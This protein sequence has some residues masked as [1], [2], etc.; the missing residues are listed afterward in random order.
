MDIIKRQSRNNLNNFHKL[1]QLLLL[2]I[3]IVFFSCKKE[4]NSKPNIILIMADDLGVETLGCYGSDDYKTPNLDQLA[5]EGMKFENCYS[6]PLCTPSRVQLM[7]GKYNFRN[8]IGFGLLDP[9]ERTFGHM[10]QE[11]GYETCVVGKWQLLGNEHQRK[12]A[13]GKIG[14]LPGGAGFDDYLLWQVDDRGS[15]YKDPLLH[16]KDAGNELYPGEFGPDKFVE[17]I[18]SFMA[19]NTNNPFFVYYPMVITHDPFVPTPDN[20]EFANFD[21]KGGTNDP[22]YFG[23]MVGYMDQL[24][25]RIIKKTDELGIRENTLILFI[26]DN[27]T[28][29]DVMSSRKGNAVKGMKGHTLEAGTHVPF[30]ANWK[31]TIMPNQSN[32][33]LIDFT[34]FVPSLLEMVGQKKLNGDGVS[35]YPQLIGDSSAETRDWVFCHYDPRWGKFKSKR[36]VQNTRWKLY[37]SGEFYDVIADPMEE[38]SLSVDELPEE[39]QL[40]ASKFRKVLDDMR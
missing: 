22:K 34:D 26:G 13:G 12:L 5:N 16:K 32:P 35:F 33:N 31:G 7:T 2:L 4:S 11:A 8:Y 9:K 18:E 14:M 36:Y 10:L 30:I 6:T 23:E 40:I 28:D 21:P 38:K 3:T 20:A 15:R 25:G 37:E 39:V 1:G 27:G 17:H 24:I 29:R 19:S